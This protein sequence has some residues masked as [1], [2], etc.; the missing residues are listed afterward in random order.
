MRWSRIQEVWDRIDEQ[1]RARWELLS[2]A[3]VQAI[4]GDRDSLLDTLCERYELPRDK[5]NWQVSIW[6]NGYT[7]SW[8]YGGTPRHD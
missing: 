1:V 7:D 6:Q 8:L 4:G 3:E 2:A 5:A